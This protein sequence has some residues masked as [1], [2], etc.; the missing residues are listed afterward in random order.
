ME[1]LITKKDGRMVKM[2][3]DE[4]VWKKEFEGQVLVKRE[5]TNGHKRVRVRE[6]GSWTQKKE[7]PSEQLQQ[8][9]A[10]KSNFFT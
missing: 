3:L 1:L 2:K 7:F 5:A 8:P 6:R 9:V 4:T 10:M